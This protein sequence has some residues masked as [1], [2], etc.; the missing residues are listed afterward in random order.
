MSALGNGVAALAVLAACHS[1]SSSAPTN[2]PAT[3]APQ[4]VATT[5]APVV[6]T[7]PT[8]AALSVAP[9]HAENGSDSFTA[10]RTEHTAVWT[11]SEFI[12]WGG[13]DAVPSEENGYEAVPPH[14]LSDGARYNPETNSWS[15][16]SNTGAPG[17]RY[18]HTAAWTGEEMIVWGG[19]GSSNAA[20]DTGARYNPATNTWRAMP[21]T[22]APV[23]RGSHSAVWTGTELIVFGGRNGIREFADGAAY[24][25]ATDAWRAIASAPAPRFNHAVAWTGDTMIVWGGQSGRRVVNSG[26]MYR[27][28]DNRWVEIPKRG[29]PAARER[30]LSAWSGT[31]FVV[32][33]GHSARGMLSTGGRFTPNGAWQTIT[34]NSRVR[35][36]CVVWT[37]R[38][39]IVA[40][41]YDGGEDQEEPATPSFAE[42]DPA[43]NTWT[44]GAEGSIAD[45][46][47]CVWTGDVFLSFGGF[48]GSNLDGM[49]TV[50]RPL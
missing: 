22:G 12:V 7:P 44:F 1:S 13:D 41:S 15:P 26:A 43:T 21:A 32:L 38:R 18:A 35:P 19:M 37:G 30:S 29:A 10:G 4:T 31:E 14:P 20:T 25:P 33:G 48:D 27:P 5:P 17:A 46:A 49:L 36:G 8:A 28:A 6:P 23:A 11:G 3:P 42:L 45:G 9:G 40:S 2:A 24:N 34:S 47:R 39:L 50:Y 16:V